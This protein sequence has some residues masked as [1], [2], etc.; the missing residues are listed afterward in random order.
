M[1]GAA[2]A[3][4]T[5]SAEV[6]TE[7][8]ENSSIQIMIGE[9]S[10]DCPAHEVFCCSNV[11]AGRYLRVASLK[12]L[13]GETLDQRSIGTT[14]NCPDSLGCLKVLGQHDDLLR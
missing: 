14:A 4:A 8:L 2:I 10:A 3:T 12:Q 9:A 5:A 11:S 13:V 6:L 7:A 1:L